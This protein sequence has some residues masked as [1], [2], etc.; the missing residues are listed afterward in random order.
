MATLYH[1]QCNVHVWRSETSRHVDALLRQAGSREV[2]LPWER[3]DLLRDGLHFSAASQRDFEADL[4]AWFRGQASPPTCLAVV[5]DSTVAYWPEASARLAR[6]MEEVV[7][8]PTRVRAVCGSGFAARAR[9]NESFRHLLREARWRREG[10]A[11]LFV[12]GWNDEGRDPHLLSQAVRGCLREG[13][14]WARW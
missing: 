5:A 8:I 9:H 12:G 10:E 2:H 11:V 7:G 1:V 14:G 6:T 4:M 3:Y 13:E